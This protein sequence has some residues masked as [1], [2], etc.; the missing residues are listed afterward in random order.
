MT[1]YATTDPVA[2]PDYGIFV[3]LNVPVA[4]ALV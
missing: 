2:V 3:K 4:N 1:I